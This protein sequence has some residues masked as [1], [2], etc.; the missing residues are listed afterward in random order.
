MIKRTL[1]LGAWHAGRGQAPTLTELGRSIRDF[2]E[3]GPEASVLNVGDH[4]TAVV[5]H[6][7]PTTVTEPLKLQLFSLRDPSGMPVRYT[8]GQPLE[9]FKLEDGTFAGDVAHVTLWADGWIGQ[10]WYRDVPRVTRLCEYLRKQLN[11]RI[12]TT[13]LYDSDLADDLNDIRGQLRTVAISNNPRHPQ[14]YK[15]TFATLVP[16]AFGSKAPSFS[17]NLGMGRFGPRDQYLPEQLSDA[18]YEEI[19]RG[20]DQFDSFVVSGRSRNTGKVVT[21]NLLKRRIG[22]QVELPPSDGMPGLPDPD[23][24]F[25]ALQRTF[26]KRSDSLRR[27]RSL[28]VQLP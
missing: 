4:R 12:E 10:D 21:I 20:L 28:A 23:A 19:E 16:S 7:I 8:P 6:Q 1:V 17:I 5:V 9:D 24:T 13:S 15:G 26:I 25:S 22:D 11:V 27:A 2:V 3:Q 14:D 18:V